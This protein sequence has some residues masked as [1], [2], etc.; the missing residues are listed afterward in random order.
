MYIKDFRGKGLR[1]LGR[2]YAAENA[3]LMGDI[4]LGEGASVWPGAV[5]RGDAAA[6]VIGENC[7]LQDNVVVHTDPEFPAVLA[8]NCL[9]GHGAILHS[10]TLGEGVLIGMGAIVMTG[11]Q[12]GEGSIIAA[13]A[14]VSSNKVI[15]PH[16]VVMGAGRIARQAAPEER[17]RT[18]EECANY[19]AL[20]AELLVELESK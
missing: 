6:I 13:G 7:N 1:V 18:I 4:T 15:P 3:T 17:A 5:L 12:I 16:S 2:A 10:C 20:A 11:A 8:E 9:V 14:L 19:R